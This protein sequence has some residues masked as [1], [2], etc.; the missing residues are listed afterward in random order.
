MKST[1]IEFV[2][3]H[4]HEQIKARSLLPGSRLPSVRALAGLLHL[5]VSTIVE[6]YERLASQGIIEAKTGSGFFVAGPLAPL[7]I[8]EI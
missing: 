7:S 8:S 6:A 1:K 2:I 5:S 3:Q 4:I